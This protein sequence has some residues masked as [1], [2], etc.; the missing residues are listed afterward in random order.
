[1]KWERCHGNKRSNLKR[2]K[3]T[4]SKHHKGTTVRY[5]RGNKEGEK[6]EEGSQPTWRKGSSEM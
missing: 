6:I 4:T 3:R 2:K 1:M 5:G